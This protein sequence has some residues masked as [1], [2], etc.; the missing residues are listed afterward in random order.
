MPKDISS[1]LARA[2]ITSVHTELD[3][4]HR[5]VVAGA[6]GTIEE[7]T[8]EEYYDD[9]S[10]ADDDV[11][12]G[13]IRF[14]RSRLYGRD[15][16]LE[17]L[18][19]IY[20]QV[21]GGDLDRCHDREEMVPPSSSSSSPSAPASAA[22]SG[23]RPKTTCRVVFLGGLAG[24]GK[25]QLVNEF[26]ASVS[27][28]EQSISSNKNIANILSSRP[29]FGRGKFEQFENAAPF[30]AIADALSMWT[31]QLLDG[32]N[33]NSDPEELRLVKRA[34][35]KA[36]LSGSD[37]DGQVLLK[38]FP[39]LRP[40][41][42]LDDNG[43]EVAADD[44]DS[45]QRGSMKLDITR[46]KIV[47]KNFAL[48]LGEKQD[49]PLV[50]FIDDLQWADEASLE[51]VTSLVLNKTMQHLLFIGTF[52]SNEVDETTPALKRMKE[53]ED[54]VPAGIVTHMEITG[55][56]PKDIAQFVADSI[57]RDVEDVG[58][59]SDL[60]YKK[61][62]GNI[63]F[64]RHAL[65][66]L[67]RRN[68][69]YYD[70]ICY[71]WQ[72]NLDLFSSQIDDFVAADN[73][74]L[75]V[76]KI[77]TI[78][79][80]SQRALI[81]MAYSQKMISAVTLHALMQ[82]NGH[83][84]I[85]LQRVVNILLE[86]VAEGLLLPTE[87]G[88]EYA[89]AHDIIEH[90]AR[91]LVPEGEERDVLLVE[92]ATVLVEREAIDGDE[93]MLFAA[94]RHF[95]SVPRKY[96]ESLDDLAS[97]N[98]R[99]AKSATAKA[100]VPQAAELLRSGVSCLDNDS[101]WTSNYDLSFDLY[102]RLLSAEFALR[103]NDAAR[104]AIDVV[105]SNA[106][107][108]RD[109]SASHLIM[110]RLAVETSD[111]DYSKAVEIGLDLLTNEYGESNLQ[112]HPSKFAL[113]KEKTK[114][115][116]A[117]KGRPLISLAGMPLM[118]DAS[119]MKLFEEIQKSTFLCGASFEPLMRMLS[120]RCLRIAFTQGIYAE[121]PII[122]LNYA[123]ALQKKNQSN[124]SSSKVKRSYRYTRL[125]KLVQ[126][127]FPE[128][129]H[130]GAEA[131]KF[132]FRAAGLTKNRM[133]FK[134]DIVQFHSIYRRALS[135]GVPDIG[136]AAAMTGVFCHFDAGLPLTSLFGA[137]LMAY[138][139]TAAEMNQRGF[140]IVLKASRQF[141]LNLIGK[142]EGNPTSFKGVA[143]DENETLA[144]LEGNSR[145]MALRDISAFRLQLA[146][147]FD[148]EQ[149]MIE[150]I[151]RLKEY[152][153][154]DLNWPRGFHRLTFLGLSCLDIGFRKKKIEY[155]RLAKTIMQRYDK[156]NKGGSVN[157]LPISAC[158][159][160]IK[161]RKRAMFDQAMEACAIAGMKNMEAIMCEQCGVMLMERK[162]QVAAAE[163]YLVRSYFLYNEWGA[164]RKV[165]ELVMK[166]NFLDENTALKRPGTSSVCS[167]SMAG[168]D[169]RVAGASAYGY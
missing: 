142:A 36:G 83:D 78:S 164:R 58:P 168:W 53:I 99:A 71:E 26:I 70:V 156:L 55:L 86:A 94:A 87:V 101:C 49:R 40:L 12:K 91:S 82:A 21:V 63:F 155:L 129:A 41:L 2:S 114:L 74:G 109:K 160:A 79:E 33:E 46:L 121:L 38:I 107:S 35:S 22:L 141:H 125:A 169:G 69:L 138:E 29:L 115:R 146:Y 158:F 161:S 7:Q 59:L 68:V 76:S 151:E 119:R 137:K 136:F 24:T 103:N 113:I 11:R 126:E 162:D 51:L 64:V 127:K 97:L 60:I 150:M 20:R 96:I 116:I 67:V 30:S 157:T 144:K 112:L 165:E 13:K 18:R 75:I 143:L 166:Y 110:M 65:E 106:T 8:D 73:E 19:N 34:I 140:G 61:T 81:L 132:D 163:E 131:C 105:L 89:F 124:P 95:N 17:A 3:T 134:D 10:D 9:R 57:G 15:K 1:I 130:Y 159:D 39:L 128:S 50:L 23:V 102:N 32:N 152:P 145:K 45:N 52:R 139:R 147:I 62:L 118:K 117:R 80:D 31:S 92:I 85:D 123:V 28:D 154:D 90:A 104:A 108:L 66:E 6:H 133:P 4:T 56:L 84:R 167:S 16:E 135:N 120:L 100:S 153:H 148:D 14:P 122:C 149:V 42:S 54:G 72:W 111:R 93:W 43:K 48:A 44:G 77:R 25:S 37:E 47:V 5:D 98:L 27:N 88:K